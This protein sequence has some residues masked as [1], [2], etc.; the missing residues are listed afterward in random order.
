MTKLVEQIPSEEDYKKT[1]DN[2]KVFINEVADKIEHGE[3]L[4]SWEI[5]WAAGILRAYAAQIPT[6]R[7]HDSRFKKSIQKKI[8]ATH[9]TQHAINFINKGLSEEES[10]KLIAKSV[11]CDSKTARECFGLVESNDETK[12]ALQQINREKVQAYFDVVDKWGEP[13]K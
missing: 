1:S 12:R 8:T 7:R 5:E 13:S 2:Q 10:A 6:E 4:D 11:G 3:L 9:Y